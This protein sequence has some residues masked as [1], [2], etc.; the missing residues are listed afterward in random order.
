MAS[1][2]PRLEV[3]TPKPDEHI[4][5]PVVAISGRADGSSMVHIN[6]TP[7]AGLEDGQFTATATVAVGQVAGFEVVAT[8]RRGRTSHEHVN[9]VREQVRDEEVVY[10]EDDVG[11]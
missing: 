9:V 8:D 3:Y 10:M 7:V 6:G 4:T 11:K 1:A 5:G 2:P